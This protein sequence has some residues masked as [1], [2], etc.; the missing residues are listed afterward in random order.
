[1]TNTTFAI[2][3]VHAV[4]FKKQRGMP[5]ERP[6]D[7]TLH[8]RTGQGIEGDW[9]A[10]PMSPRQVLVTRLEDLDDFGIAPGELR[11]NIVLRGVPTD[12][13]VPGAVLT[14]GDGASVRLTFYCE[15]CKRIGHLIKSYHAIM[16]RRGILGVVLTN[17]AICAGDQVDIRPEVFPPLSSV[18]YDRFLNFIEKVPTGKVVTYKD[19]TIGMGVAES[20]ARA[21]PG[22]IR[23]TADNYPV[24]RIVDSGGT[25]IPHVLEQAAK[26]TAEDVLVEGTLDLLG[27]F[28]HL[29]V[30]IRRYAWL[31]DSL[32]RCG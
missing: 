23:R 5:M 10:H 4:F 20:Y 6:A 12:T 22:Y 15:P 25:L 2:G 30:D 31:D 13:F 18:P 16:Q 24:H 3:Y 32:Y 8:M 7:D 28:P 27:N 17:G 19:I 21:V 26:L 29:F 14:A 1:M 9:N 11:E